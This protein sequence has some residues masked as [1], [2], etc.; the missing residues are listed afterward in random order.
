MSF[1]L[2]QLLVCD[3]LLE[4]RTSMW[5]DGIEAGLKPPVE[6]SV[7]SS[8]QADLA[9][10]R[11]LTEHIPVSISFAIHYREPLQRFIIYIIV[12]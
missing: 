4:T 10:L 6:N 7:L 8:F 1:Q 9:S 3:W 11:S 12:H 2:S 5:E